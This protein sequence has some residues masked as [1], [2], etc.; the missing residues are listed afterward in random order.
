MQILPVQYRAIIGSIC[1]LV[2]QYMFESCYGSSVF[3]LKFLTA[4]DIRLKDVEQ[5]SGEVV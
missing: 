3:L 4:S 1:P 2:L 5:C